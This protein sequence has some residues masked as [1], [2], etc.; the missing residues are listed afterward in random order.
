[1]IK[2][3]ILKILFKFNIWVCKRRIQPSHENTEHNLAAFN[4]IFCHT[5]Y[6]VHIYTVLVVV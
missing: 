3:D 6:D 5:D 1:M 4:N 2:K